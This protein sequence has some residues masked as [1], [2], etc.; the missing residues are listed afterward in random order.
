[1]I[2]SFPLHVPFHVPRRSRTYASLR[3][4]HV[5]ILVALGAVPPALAAEQGADRTGSVDKTRNDRAKT[6]LR[7]PVVM[8]H[9]RV[10]AQ[11]GGTVA[12]ALDEQRRS[13]QVTTILSREQIE[14]APETNLA[15]IL[16]RLPGVSAYSNMAGGQAATGESQFMTIRGLDSSYNAYTLNGE[17]IAPADPSTRAI[18]FDM[19]APYGI[20]AIK[21]S[22][23]TNAEMDGDAIGG[24]IDIRTPT[25][26]DFSGPY[27]KIILQGQLN[28]NAARTG[29]PDLGGVAQAEFARRFGR[30]GRFGV[31]ATGYYTSKH[32][33]ANAVAPNRAYVP[34]IEAQ[35][36]VAT[37]DQ[38]SQLTTTQVKYDLFT[39]SIKRYGGSL[40]LN[41]KGERHEFYALGTWGQYTTRID[42]NQVGLR[43]ADA[44]YGAD[45][46]YRSQG[47][48]RA[49]YFTTNDSAQLLTTQKLGGIS[50]IGRWTASYDVF[51][52]YG[53]QASPN[54]V[55]A[56]MY[57]NG[58]I[59][60]P[61]TFELANT[62]LPALVGPS[63]ALAEL[64]DQNFSR[65]WKTQGR[66][67]Q[68][69]AD[70]YGVHAD[71]A[72]R[73]GNTIL[74]TIQF[75]FKFSN[76]QR[77][78]WSHPYFHSDNNFIYDGP[79]FGGQNWPYTNGA[80]PRVGNI[81]GYQVD[82]FGGK[83]GDF[84]I[85][86]RDWIKDTTVPYKYSNDPQGAGNYTRN[87]W[88]ANTSTGSEKIYAGFVSLAL[89]AGDVDIRPGFRYEFTDFGGTHWQSN[90][91]NATGR[92]VRIGQ[93]YGTP[94]PY[95]N[96][97]WRPTALSVLRFS[98]RRGLTRPAYGLINGASTLSLDP[99]TNA[100]L[101]VSQPNPD[102][103][104]TTATMFDFSA[105]LYNRHAG[106]VSASVYYKQIEKFI[107]TSV[108]NANN[109]A[110]LGG[111][112]PTNATTDGNT[113]YRMPVNGRGATLE[114]I[115]LSAQQ[116]LYFL[117][118]WLSGFGVNGNVTLQ[119]SNATSNIAG[120]PDT[121]LPRAPEMMYNL[122]FY[123]SRDRIHFDL[124]YN[125][126]GTQLLSVNS[127][128]PDFY[129]QP[130]QRLDLSAK[131]RFG[132]GLTGTLAM[133][134]LLNTP[135][136]WE[137]MG[138]GKS[139]LAYD[140]SANGAFVQTGR[141]YLAGLTGEF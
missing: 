129:L 121:A 62:T 16:T 81:P 78:A 134:N 130:T 69:T 9:I 50:H 67:A 71:A 4:R 42:D 114:G 132:W 49:Q 68:S 52:S 14:R 123:Y 98:V 115:E 23:S 37:L 90:G 72:Y 26:F 89:R 63:G 29:T 135:A 117:P 102:L 56:S 2:P 139:Y 53:E 36:G 84:R 73:F 127:R 75:G 39:S 25:A 128:V 116:T 108:S 109:S 141:M 125:Y 79:F 24:A 104:P 44:G 31:Y 57:G 97:N 8:E 46:L 51:N 106:V 94:L 95:L 41:F 133:Q 138:K 27:R 77:R 21:V 59:P 88:N 96:V 105:A 86:D 7:K 6:A 13:S 43:G 66:D 17:R 124:N 113:T 91:D 40:S 101:S 58:S 33:L 122:G 82:A 19:L 22:K 93:S 112:V 119:H 70:M 20:T 3:S 54:T 12:A 118:G 28:D 80:G 30:D 15:D 120:H 76:T 48:A 110:T 55:E 10:R 47:M 111:N 11:R 99:V 131:Y 5:A 126:I 35:S 64:R 18:S 87:D 137:T 45:G 136:F 1:M 92:F 65:F 85:L 32:V 74:Q 83:L 140:S 107:F 34:A 60:G 38:A 100:I 61:F 103:R